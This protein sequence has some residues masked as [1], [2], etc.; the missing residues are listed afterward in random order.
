[1]IEGLKVT[2]KWGPIS[3]SPIVNV[4]R[5]EWHLISSMSQSKAKHSNY[6]Q[7]PFFS[8]TEAEFS[9]VSIVDDGNGMTWQIQKAPSAL[10]N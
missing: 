6:G 1:M 7:L 3:G 2:D 9:S 4:S 10:P 5:V 8:K